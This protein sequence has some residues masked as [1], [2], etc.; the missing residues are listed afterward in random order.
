MR[1]KHI[2][3]DSLKLPIERPKDFLIVFLLAVLSEIITHYFY[4]LKL[5][6]WTSL[7]MILNSVITIIILGLM[8]NITD[9]AIFEE[10][11]KLKFY[12]HLMEGLKDY[13]ITYYY[14]ILSLISSSLFIVPTGSYSR[15][16]HI[17][18]YILNNNIDV[19]LMTLSELSHQLP[20]PLQLDLQHSI[21]INLLIA[22]VIF[23]TLTTFGFIGKILLI[24]S[25]KLSNALDLRVIFKIIKNIGIKRYLKFLFVITIIILVLFNT[26]VLL[27]PYISGIF[28]SGL[29]EATVLF[30]LTNAFYL[31]IEIN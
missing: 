31:F 6:N 26:L 28:I 10:K 29:L 4:S 30:I 1:I 8:V 16:M 2:I 12:E 21:Q 27:E 17:H 14:M 9:H 7:A 23:I 5:G 19:T 15:L 3:S 24:K 13:I 11:V 25:D 18:E 20:V 22:I